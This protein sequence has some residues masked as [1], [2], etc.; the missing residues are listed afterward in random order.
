MFPGLMFLVVLFPILLGVGTVFIPFKKRN[1]ML[2]FLETG[3]IINSI[4]VW[5]ILILKVLMHQRL[6]IPQQRF[7]RYMV[8]LLGHLQDHK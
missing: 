2:I 5:C 4:F 7:F 8:L 6:L 3:V 1:H